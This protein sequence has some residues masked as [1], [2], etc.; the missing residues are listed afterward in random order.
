MRAQ[1]SQ[2]VLLTEERDVVSMSEDELE[3]GLSKEA[4]HVSIKYCLKEP[5][6]WDHMVLSLCPAVSRR[7]CVWCGV[8]CGVCVCVC[9]RVCVSVTE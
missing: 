7:V 8:V 6:H 9:V 1:T 2:I 5:P 3:A 4:S